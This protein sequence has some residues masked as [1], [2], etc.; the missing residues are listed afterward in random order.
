MRIKIIFSTLLLTF[1]Y[2]CSNSIQ[3]ITSM[4]PAYA[5]YVSA[6]TTGMMSRTKAI[7]L[8]LNDSL[9]LKKEWKEKELEKYIEIS[10]A[11]QGDF[12]INEVGVLQFIPA[13]PLPSATLFTAKLELDQLMEVDKGHENFVFQFSTYAQQAYLYNHGL[14]TYDEY[15]IENLYLTGV[16]RFTDYEDSAKV[17]DALTATY[18]KKKVKVHLERNGSNEFNYRI[19]SLERTYQVGKL[20]LEL[21]G[22]AFGMTENPKIDQTLAALGDFYPSNYVVKDDGDQTLEIAFT[23]NL[24][25]SQDLKG[26]IRIGGDENPSYTIEENRITFFYPRHIEGLKKV[27]V[28][29]GI[30]NFRG[31]KMTQK[32][33]YSVEFQSPK[34]RVRLIGSGNIL[35]NSQ[36]LIFPF[37][38][39]ALKNVTVRV[40]RIRETNVH[41]FLQSNNLDGNDELGRFGDVVYEKDLALDKD[42]KKNLKEWNRQVLDLTKIIS[43]SPGSIYQVGI[44]FDR[45][46]AICDCVSEEEDDDDDEMDEYED[47]E[48]MEEIVLNREEDPFWNERLWRSWGL[49]R[50]YQSYDYYYDDYSP[51]NKR[52]YYGKAATRN[53]LAS[54]LGIIYKLD[55]DKTAHVYVNNLISTQPMAGVTL[56]FYSYTKELIASG[57]S[58]ASGKFQLK[59]AKKPF[60]LVAE[61][62]SQRGYLKLRDGY[63]N[64]LS[65]FN[66]EGQSLTQGV[67]GYLYGERGVWRPGDS[68]FLSFMLRDPNHKLPN[69]YPIKF[70]LKNPSGQVVHETT[71]NAGVGGIYDF[72]CKTS[73]DA[74][75][76]NYLATVAVGNLNFQKV[77]RV[78]TIKPNRLKINFAKL[79]DSISTRINHE[80]SARWLH[81][82]K[83]KNLSASVNVKHFAT[84]THFDGFKGYCFDSPLRKYQS[85]ETHIYDGELSEDG[86]INVQTE[87]SNR[88]DAPGKLTSVYNIKVFEASGEF[89]IDSRSET[90]SPYNTYIGLSSGQMNDNQSLITDKKYNLGLVAVNKDGK[91]VNNTKVRVRIY[92][93]QW[94]WWYE[95]GE[96]DLMNYLA[97]TGTMSIKDTLISLK[98]G[99]GTVPMMIRGRSYGRYLV[100]ATD[101]EGM[102]QTGMVLRFDRPYWIRGN[103]SNNEEAKMLSFATDKQ[104]YTVG[105]KTEITIPSNE[106]GHALISI[107]SGQKVLE[108]HWVPTTKNET[109]FSF[110]TTKAMAPSVY[111]HVTLLQPHQL[112]KNNLPIR[113]YGVLP[114]TVEDLSTHLNPE[115]HVADKVRPES[116]MRVA[117]S[118]KSGKAMAYTLAIVDEGLLDL[119][120]FKT[121]NPWSH[122]NARLSLGVKTWDMY[123]QVI[124]AFAGNLNGLIAIGGSDNFKLGTPNKANRFPPMVK[125]VGPFYLKAGQKA[126]HYLDLPAYIGSVRVMVIAQ[127]NDQA[128]GSSEKD[129]RIAKPLMVL[130]TFPRTAMPG[131]EID[132]PVTIFAMDKKIKNVEVS[133]KTNEMMEVLDERVKSISFEEE[134]EQLVYYK[135]R[136]KKAIGMGSL[137]INAQSGSETA[138]DR[139]EFDILS[140]NPSI[141]KNESFVLQP[142]E[143]KTVDVKLFGMAGT[144]EVDIEASSIPSLRLNERMDYLLQYPHG[145]VEQTTSSVFPQVYLASL[146]NL[147]RE[148]KKKIQTNIQAGI[149]RLYRFQT[150]NGGLSYWPGND[151]ANEWGTNYAGHFMLEAKKAGYQVSDQFI[152]KWVQFQTERANTWQYAGHSALD[153]AYRLYTL[154]IAGKPAMGAMNRLKENNYLGPLERWQLAAAYFRSGQKEVAKNMIE[155]GD[156]KKMVSAYAYNNFGSSI[157]DKALCLEIAVMLD[158]AKSRDELYLEITQALG[159]TTW[160]STQE[161]AYSLRAVQYFHFGEGKNGQSTQFA[162]QYNQAERKEIAAN[163][164]VHVEKLTN[165]LVNG[166]IKIKNTSNQKLYFSFDTK[167]VPYKNPQ[168]EWSKGMHLTVEYLTINN[169]RLDPKKIKQ[170]TEFKVRVHVNHQGR[171]E[172]IHEI[173]L[174]NQFPAGWE[175]RNERMTGYFTS[176]NIDYQDFRDNVVYSYFDLRRNER[177]SFEFFFVAA[178]AGDYYLPGQYVEAMYDSKKSSFINGQSVTVTPD[179]NTRPGISL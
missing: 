159:S 37:E 44:K 26:L 101:E 75:T 148:E 38:S 118:E 68:L 103:E 63:V 32:H 50:D 140:P 139:V 91:K 169:E 146:I 20:H 110:T 107:E 133:L 65:K 64:S 117:V 122:F 142:G 134:G 70:S 149:K 163:S 102:H 46:D 73:Y 113:M 121:P 152:N 52:Y 31:H 30:Q 125:C 25:V 60:L 34:P 123:D 120:H 21:D 158:Q 24:S 109:K 129:V 94:R 10:P 84:A 69:D 5:K 29:P 127:S 99:K 7:T 155:A 27:E 138:R 106:G 92:K 160:L 93:L 67:N 41:H 171:D 154:A 81:G 19:D 22:K 173:A 165:D 48:E 141:T 12:S 28:F 49:N 77:F 114:I 33:T 153:Q 124:G 76:G 116:K 74:P 90:T 115:I 170:G 137:E 40:V 79:K 15:E 35:P 151:Q 14:R 162:Y 17:A 9:L 18:N 61:Q 174:T 51:C 112:T 119:T 145:C 86:K 132:V 88:Y 166:K 11:I 62:G 147:N 55:E 172:D 36:G 168:K 47:V 89:S 82:A 4:D 108:S 150:A 175:L 156:L 179:E 177:K 3:G 131:D 143:S 98:N 1:I 128:Y 126:N 54:D 176:G 111:V 95:Q 85:D 56:K 13:E 8:H 105:Q 72:K 100:T 16:I 178:Y 164:S 97:R 39:I 161:T 104:S 66:V 80:L 144:N 2:A 43:P 83:A 59:L 58:D 130:S 53:L 57:T 167:G 157:R 135:L 136:I 78:E 87:L 45:D 96:E 23:E 71:S 6:Y 42:S